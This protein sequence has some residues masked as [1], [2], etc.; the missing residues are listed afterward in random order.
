MLWI[1]DPMHGNTEITSSGF[2]TR[3]F[4]NIR[5]ELEQAFDMHA[6]AGKRLGGVHIELTGENVTECLGG[7]R[8][9]NESDL[10]R[11][12]SRQSIRG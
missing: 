11:A 4:D 9:L 7:A 1:C 12:Y 10:E 5:S 3:R 8:E 6:A 2:K